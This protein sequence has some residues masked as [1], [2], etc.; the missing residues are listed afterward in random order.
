MSRTND[1]KKVFKNLLSQYC[2]SCF[3][4]ACP[5]DAGFPRVEYD[6]KQLAVD[7]V[8]YEKIILT[9]N[10]YDKN[11]T[12]TIDAFVDN[13]I[14]GIDLSI[15]Y[16]ESV[17]YQFYYGKDRQPVLEADKTI[18]RIMLTFEVRIYLRSEQ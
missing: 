18:K 6:F 3:F 16:T 14:N 12:E 4:G 13:L 5:P 1:H 10:C 17:Y 2:P 7:N 15:F 9:L 11:Q 8:P